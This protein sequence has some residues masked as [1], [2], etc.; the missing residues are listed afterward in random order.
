MC[1][2]VRELG[3]KYIVCVRELCSRYRECEGTKQ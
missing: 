2:C 1:V 3:S